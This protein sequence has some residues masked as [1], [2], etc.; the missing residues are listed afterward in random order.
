[1]GSRPGSDGPGEGCRSLRR[2]VTKAEIVGGFSKGHEGRFDQTARADSG[3][4]LRLGE[5]KRTSS[6][7]QNSSRGE[8][9]LWQ[10]DR[11]VPRLQRPIQGEGEVQRRQRR[12]QRQGPRQRE[13]QEGEGR[14]QKEAIEDLHTGARQ[15]P[16][17][18]QSPPGGR[19]VEAEEFN[20]LG[21]GA[22]EREAKAPGLSMLDIIQQS[23]SVLMKDSTNTMRSNMETL[24]DRRNP[25]F[26]LRQVRME[27]LEEEGTPRR[28]TEEAARGAFMALNHLAGFGASKALTT[29]SSSPTSPAHEDERGLRSRAEKSVS[30][31]VQRNHMWGVSNEE[32]N[33]DSFFKGRG[34]NYQGDE[35]KTAQKLSWEAVKQSLPEG[36]GSLPLADFAVWGRLHTYKI[37]RNI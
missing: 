6:G 18:E 11:E 22:Q 9:D 14:R 5:L 4:S 31:L 16:G 1:M 8:Q 35:I 19:E 10:G 25:L 3:R 26:P 2:D 17:T 24:P 12:R 30:R 21:S 37:S 29:S 7:G 32:V 20:R 23:A 13:E 34:V 33:F 28:L 36:V 15:A 27:E